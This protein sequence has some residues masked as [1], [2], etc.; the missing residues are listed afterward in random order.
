MASIQTTVSTPSAPAAATRAD[1]AQGRKEGGVAHT[2]PSAAFAQLMQGWD[3]APAWHADGKELALPQEALVPLQQAD[4]WALLGDVRSLVGQTQG[5]DAQD[6]DAALQDGSVLQLRLDAGLLPAA[7]AD[8]CS[9]ALA[10]VAPGQ[11]VA[12]V[13]A[14][15]QPL[16]GDGAVQGAAA[17]NAAEAD[18]SCM[19]P[20]DG[21]SPAL[22]GAPDTDDVPSGRMALPG[23]WAREDAQAA[24][25][26]ALQRVVGQVE[27]WLAAAASTV[28][29]PSGRPAQ[30]QA[31]SVGSEWAVSAADSGTRLTQHAVQAAAQAQDA[32]MGSHADAPMEDMRFWLQG[33]Q[34][35][36]EV[37]LDQEGQTVR[38]QVALRGHVAHVNFHAGQAETREW[39]DAGVAQLRQMLEQQGVALEG[40]TVQAHA[41]GDTAQDQAPSQWARAP[42]RHV[43]VAVP[44]DAEG[45]V[46]AAPSGGVSLYV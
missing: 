41:G 36:A 6:H 25:P 39:L 15:V 16:L 34:Q 24:V 9:G 7:S 43:A 32:A 1:K 21:V 26:V 4:A 11:Q 31:R 3:A 38:V 35:R 23:A 29:K 5:L 17:Q 42:V 33:K 13:A 28:S 19:A 8:A 2:H 20:D 10:Q 22:H 44:Q 12:T 27:Q 40:V 30:E 37:V 14:G 45:A 18:V 46:R